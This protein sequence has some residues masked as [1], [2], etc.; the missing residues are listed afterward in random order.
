M[1]VA[2]QCTGEGLMAAVKTERHT[3]AV[4]NSEEL[5]IIEILIRN[6][7]VDSY[8]LHSVRNIILITRTCQKYNE[9]FL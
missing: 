1:H 7:T 4:C 3:I 5:K 9:E 6:S 8:P 2:T